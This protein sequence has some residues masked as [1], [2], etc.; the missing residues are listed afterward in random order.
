MTSY[1]GARPTY[2]VTQF[3][4][5]YNITQIAIYKLA[6]VGASL[7]LPKLTHRD[8]RTTQG[9]FT[10]TFSYCDIDFEQMPF[11]WVSRKDTAAE[12]NIYNSCTFVICEIA[13][14][15]MIVIIV[16]LIAGVNRPLHRHTH[17]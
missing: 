17:T 8:S 11:H 3:R 12:L 2:D 5:Q 4:P 13:I 14:A 7:S 9:L 1:D 6:S 15:S 16:D 10:P